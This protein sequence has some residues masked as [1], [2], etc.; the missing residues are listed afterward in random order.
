LVL[1]ATY[2]LFFLGLAVL[3]DGLRGFI[4]SDREQMI[5]LALMCSSGPVAIVGQLIGGL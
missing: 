3:Y 1:L 4:P 5:G 2:G